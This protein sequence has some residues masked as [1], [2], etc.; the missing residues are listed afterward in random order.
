MSHR[1]VP[2]SS[3]LGRSLLDELNWDEKDSD[4][5]PL[6]DGEDESVYSPSMLKQWKSTSQGPVPNNWNAREYPIDLWYLIAMYIAPED[7]GRFALLCQATNHVV[8]TVPFWIRLFR[9]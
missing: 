3:K 1:H 7:V 9:K 6:S 4:D 8:N 5:P 2:V